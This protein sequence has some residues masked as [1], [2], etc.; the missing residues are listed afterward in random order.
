M[1]STSINEPNPANG[2][3]NSIFSKSKTIQ[4]SI[5]SFS[6]NDKNKNK[7]T[8]STL[9]IDLI[10][11]IIVINSKL[12]RIKNTLFIENPLIIENMHSFM[13]TRISQFNI[14]TLIQQILHLCDLNILNSEIKSVIELFDPFHNYNLELN[15]QIFL[16]KLIFINSEMA[17]SRLICSKKSVAMFG[18]FVSF[19]DLEKEFIRQIWKIQTFKSKMIKKMAEMFDRETI[20]N[21]YSC[22]SITLKTIGENDLFHFLKE[23]K[24]EISKNHLKFFLNEIKSKSD[25]INLTDLISYFNDRL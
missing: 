13:A 10:K 6:I 7:Q 12:E 21:M 17:E 4:N 23:N 22:V 24:E 2:W 14:V 9:M 3:V 5:H 16:L 15:E 1:K 8:P 19:S 11:R 25:H 18:E 20:T